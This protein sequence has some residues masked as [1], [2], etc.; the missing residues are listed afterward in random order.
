MLEK[1]KKLVISEELKRKVEIIYRLANNKH[2]LTNGSL[3]RYKKALVFLKSPSYI[4]PLAII[5]THYIS[6]Y[7]NTVH[8]FV[9]IYLY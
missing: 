7:F 3:I 9:S 6:C 4:C 2:S 5:D 1:T 8:T